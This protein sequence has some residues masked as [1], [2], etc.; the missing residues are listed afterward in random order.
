[1]IHP[2][3]VAWYVSSAITATNVLNT[4]AHYIEEIDE[5]RKSALDFYAFQ[6]NAYVS[7]RENLVNDSEESSDS[8]VEGEGLYFF[9]NDGE[10]S[11]DSSGS[12]DD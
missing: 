10:G 1:M 2:Y 5:N 12:D 3:F 9:D 4:R 7:Y 11:D 8:T 6:R